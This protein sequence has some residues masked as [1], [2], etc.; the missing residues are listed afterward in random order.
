LFL[1]PVCSAQEML[2]LLFSK[3]KN[4]AGGWVF[5]RIYRLI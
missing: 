1:C 2:H 3:L 5:P 4:P